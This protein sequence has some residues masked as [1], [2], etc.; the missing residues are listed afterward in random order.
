MSVTDILTDIKIIIPI[1]IN[2]L[3][4]STGI[5]VIIYGLLPWPSLV[6]QFEGQCRDTPPC[7][8]GIVEYISLL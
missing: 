1:E 6:H 5:S 4:S 7:P 3:I 8:L 2:K